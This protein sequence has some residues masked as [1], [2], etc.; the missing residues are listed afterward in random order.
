MVGS[1]PAQPAIRTVLEREIRARRLTL[2]E[3]AD[4]AERFAREHA[5]PGT[6]GLRNLQR[7]IAGRP[8]RP[9]GNA[10]VLPQ[11]A[12]LLELIFGRN[13]EELLSAPDKLVVEEPETP[14]G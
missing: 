8:G 2:E 9:N 11:T 7:L 4:Y 5:E 14:I 6:L 10:R 13:I 12:R 1:G 3:F